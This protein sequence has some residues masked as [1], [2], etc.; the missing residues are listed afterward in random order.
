MTKYKDQIFK[1]LVEI[2]VVTIGILIAF[3]LDNWNQNRNKKQ[4]EYEI[5]NQINEDLKVVLQDLKNDFIIHKIALKSHA[6]IDSMTK[7]NIPYSEEMTF[8]FYWVKEDE[9]IF[10]NKTGFE[11]LESFGT[12][13]ISNL[14]LRNSISYVYNHDFPRITKGNNLYPDIHEFLTP[15]YQL[16]FKTNINPE[17]AYKLTLEDNYTIN[18]PRE[19]KTGEISD[20]EF[21]GFS[22]INYNNIINND[23]FKFLI[24]E[25]KKYRLYKYKMYKNTIQHVEEILVMLD[26]YLKT[27]DF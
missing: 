23:E 12:N 14:E 27:S 18:Y 5:L 10:P 2:L 7:Y 11:M 1:Y 8:D 4:Q 15:Y 26:N 6:R 24:S 21:I 22:P 19:I 16:H 13:L 3:A 20:M 9:F 17:L 25:A